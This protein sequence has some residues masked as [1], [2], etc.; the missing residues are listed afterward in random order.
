[1]NEVTEIRRAVMTLVAI[2]LVAVVVLALGALMMQMA[3]AV[4]TAD[5]CATSGTPGAPYCEHTP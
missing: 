1:M 5:A 3:T 4:N 2:A